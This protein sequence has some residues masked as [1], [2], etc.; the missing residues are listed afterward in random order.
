MVSPSITRTTRGG[1]ALYNKVCAH[2]EEDHVGLKR[3]QGIGE[4]SLIGVGR[5]AS[6][7]FG[8]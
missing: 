6:L 5:R 1:E 2:E 7:G 3:C 8:E 4:W